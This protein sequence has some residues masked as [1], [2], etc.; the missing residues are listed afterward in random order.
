MSIVS[1]DKHPPAVSEQCKIARTED[2]TPCVIDRARR[3]AR[4]GRTL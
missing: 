1:T 2:A 4:A 3:S